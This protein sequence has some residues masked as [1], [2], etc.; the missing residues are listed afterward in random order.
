MILAMCRVKPVT[1]YLSFIGAFGTG[2]NVRR[3]IITNSRDGPASNIVGAHAGSSC[4]NEHFQWTDIEKSKNLS[5][6]KCLRIVDLS[7][8]GSLAGEERVQS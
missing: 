3:S 1:V 4:N 8:N 2:N 5:L 7:C 6:G